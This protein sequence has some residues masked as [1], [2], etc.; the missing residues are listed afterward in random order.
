MQSWP[1]VSPYVVWVCMSWLLASNGLSH[2][3]PWCNERL[4]LAKVL[5]ACNLW[6][7]DDPEQVEHSIPRLVMV[8]VWSPP[9]PLTV[10][11]VNVAD[12]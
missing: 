7:Q 2:D 6:Q 8:T 11:R 12:V 1:Y 10:A 9:F 4:P 3:W 5:M